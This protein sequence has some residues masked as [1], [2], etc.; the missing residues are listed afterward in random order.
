M[1]AAE[2]QERALAMKRIAL[3]ILL[4]A[5]SRASARAQQ[6]APELLFRA[7]HCL[8]VK[9][10]LP[11]SGAGKLTMGYLLDEKSYPGD[12]VLYIV[13]FAAPA[14]SNGTVFAVFL[15]SKSGHESF[16]IQNNA[17]FIL[18]K[19]EPIGVSFVTPPLGGEW[20]QEHLASGIRE[21]EKRPR[22]TISVRNL[23][24]AESSSNCE[25]YT[26]H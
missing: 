20:T 2:R 23:F 7:A 10:F 26:D 18:S 12:K 25:S 22:F 5:C 6:D 11:Q 21:I 19:R 9:N 14:R 13:S 24:A 17:G 3:V 1:K 4:L 16:N 8:A 15:T